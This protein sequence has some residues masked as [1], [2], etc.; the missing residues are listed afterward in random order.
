MD[1]DPPK[2][3]GREEP[4][5]EN[6]FLAGFRQQTPL[7][8]ALRYGLAVAAAAAAMVLR[9]ALTAW[10]G[11]G[12]PVFITFYPAVMAAALLGGLGPGLLATVLA[13]AAAAYWVFPP[14]GQFFI[15]SPVDRVGLMIFFGMGAFMSVVAD[16]F[17]RA[18]TKAAAYESEAAVRESRERYRALFEGSLDGVFTLDRLGHF[19][20]ANPAAERLT[21]LSLEQARTRNLNIASIC[22]PDHLTA[23][24]AAFEQC[25]AGSALEIETAI[26]RLDGARVELLI[27]ASPMREGGDIAGVFGIARDIT[28]R[29]RAEQVQARLAAIVESSDDA[30]LTKDLEGTITSWNAGAERLFGYPSQEIIGRPITVLLPPERQ[31]EETQILTRVRAGKRVEHFETVRVTKDQRRLDVSVAI[32]PLRDGAGVVIGASKILRDIS[33]R[34]WAERE[35]EMTA[36]FLRLVNESRGIKDLIQAAAEFFQQRSGCQAV[37]VRL[38]QGDDFPYYETRGFPREFVLTENHLC[39]Q[40]V[41]G[42]PARDAAGDPV[43]DCMCGNVICGRF[44]PAKP[45]FTPHGSFWTNS[46][47]QLL[48][49]TTE[50]DR[51]ARTRN[52]CHGEGYES[53]AL[54]ALRVGQQNLGLLQLNDRRQGRFSPESIA[55]WERLAGYLAIALAKVRADDELR[56]SNEELT[57]FNQGMVGRELRMIELKAEIN[58]LCAQLGQP[59]RYGVDADEKE[60]L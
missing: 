26:L 13:G 36:S 16:L 19:I 10:V 12:L 55:L 29:K 40:D 49:S 35:Q 1:N 48:A 27:S 32:S 25:L 42:C 51:Q 24:L 23:T 31:E 54:I 46:T 58:T 28:E 37:G 14:V 3:N 60:R 56:R 39:L 53:V 47:T 43:L 44:N 20:E 11:P 38:K 59:P 7:G 8:W 5:R 9:V 4:P 57:R 18:R 17:R 45:F 22:A 52:R 41:A 6:S 15:A 30:I 2:P 33:E 21:G 50:A 34:K